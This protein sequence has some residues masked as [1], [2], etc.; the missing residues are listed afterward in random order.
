MFESV[1]L[2]SISSNRVMM[3][4]ISSIFMDHPQ[5]F[6][7]AVSSVKEIYAFPPYFNITY[8]NSVFGVIS[9]DCEYNYFNRQTKI[10]SFNIPQ[11]LSN[12]RNITSQKVETI[13]KTASAQS[14]PNEKDIFC[15]VS[16]G[17]HCKQCTF[18][19]YID[20]QTFRCKPVADECHIFDYFTLQCTKCFSGYSLS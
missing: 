16:D 18:R 14:T 6:S 4:I 3:D 7:A 20:S 12:S 5:Y 10:I 15:L 17:P 1:A 13:S 11:K 8:D 9:F 19:F 2:S